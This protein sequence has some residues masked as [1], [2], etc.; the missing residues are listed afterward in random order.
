MRRHLLLPAV[1]VTAA[2]LV[3]GC[4]SDRADSDDASG[5]TVGAGDS[6]AATAGRGAASGA[7]TVF[8]A[9]SLTDAFTEIGDAFSAEHP[10]ATV[11]F[12]YGAS[13]DLVSSITGGDALG[14]ADVYASADEANMQALVDAGD[15]ADDP[16]VFARNQAEIAVPAGNPADVRGLDDFADDDLFIGLCAEDV[17]CGAYAREILDNAGVE[18]SIDTEEAKVTDV[19]AKVAS[20]DLD[21]GIVYVT[22]VLANDDEVDGIE[23]PADVN[24]DAVYPIATVAESENA[25]S[26]DAFVA[27]VLSD[28]GRQILADHGFLPPT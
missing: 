2:L 19:V 17:P 9:S 7:I 22:D 23:I 15:N 11:E 24:V 21:A 1:A 3:A 8:A 12:N 16:Q 27:F 6:T 13:S 26:A 14:V 28:A 18:P 10:D 20:G 4:G 25:D 5:T